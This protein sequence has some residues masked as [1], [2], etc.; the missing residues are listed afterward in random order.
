MRFFQRRPLYPCPG[1]KPNQP[2]TRSA[3]RCCEHDLFANFTFAVR[4]ES[5]Y[6][7]I[8]HTESVV[9]LM[10]KFRE[11]FAEPGRVDNLY[12]RELAH[13]LFAL[14]KSDEFGE[15][16]AVVRCVGCERHG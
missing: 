3:V 12:L 7:I 14:E 8:D 16:N 10:S 5:A 6:W 2:S 1:R 11:D 9:D 15:P 13:K 4:E